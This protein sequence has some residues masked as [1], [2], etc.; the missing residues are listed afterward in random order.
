M[1]NSVEN[2]YFCGHGTCNIPYLAVTIN[3][4]DDFL[5]ILMHFII[6]DIL[7]IM[8]KNMNIF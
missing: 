4:I 6:H 2:I 7:C 8:I 1:T 3:I 5:T